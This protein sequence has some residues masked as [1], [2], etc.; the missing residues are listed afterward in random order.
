MVLRLD[1]HI[2]RPNEY[3]EKRSFRGEKPVDWARFARQMGS[4]D[5]SHERCSTMMA[6]AAIEELIGE[7]VIRA[8]FNA[9]FE[10]EP[11]MTLAEYILV[12]ISSVKAL[13]M[14]YERYRT[15]HPTDRAFAVE[16]IA[17]LR[18]PRALDLIPTFLA[19]DTVVSEGLTVWE[20]LLDSPFVDWSRVPVEDWLALAEKHAT[21]DTS[22]RT[23]AIRRELTRMQDE[24]S[25][26]IA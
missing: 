1:D 16:F 9:V 7:E 26:D 6:C 11:G 2:E 12:H 23:Q 10:L 22:E 15:G 8:A 3:I 17:K 25:N 18:Q 14:A 24:D 20:N 13:E 5:D 4:V 21:G 19:E